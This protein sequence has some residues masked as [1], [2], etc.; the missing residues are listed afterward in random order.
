MTG[1]DEGVKIGG[2]LQK[3]IR[4]ADDQAIDLQMIKQWLQ[5]HKK[6][7]K[8]L[9][10]PLIKQPKNT[11]EDQHIKDEDYGDHKERQKESGFCRSEGVGTSKKIKYF[12]A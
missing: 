1:I 9:W 11:K 3:Y 8:R 12:G 6:D 5:V 7:Y 10:M 2:V 4:F